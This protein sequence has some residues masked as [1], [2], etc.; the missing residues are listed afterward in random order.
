MKA[1]VLK[2]HGGIENFVDDDVAMPATKKGQVRIKIKAV[3]FNPVDYQIRK[4][5]PEG[6]LVKSN[7][8]GRDLSGIVDEVHG[9]VTDFKKGDE[10]F[11]YVCNISS[12]GTYTEYVCVPS[13]LVAMKPALLSH[14]QAAAIPVAGITAWLALAKSTFGRSKSIFIAGG[15]G[16]VG[17]FAIMFSKLA[18]IKHI[19]TTAGNERS[20]NYLIQNLQL[21]KEQII[22]YHDDDFEKKAIEK[23]RGNFDIALDLVGGRMLSSCCELL[24]IDGNLA[25]VTDPPDKDAF[26]LLFQ[27]NASFH[28][29]GANAYSLSSDP[30]CWRRYQDVLTSIARRF[31]KNEIGKP[32]ITIVGSLSAETV[33]KGHQLLEHTSVQGK[34]VMTC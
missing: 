25:S 15:A 7:I 23:N 34:L 13:E 10:V 14:E 19:V 32:P 17:T 21:K 8:L 5:M 31:D 29:I 33:Q 1:V 24:A 12:S 3:S 18:G 4:G 6:R 27:K 2:Q 11:C 30:A 9:D 20:V 16:G 26:E 28:S 22:N